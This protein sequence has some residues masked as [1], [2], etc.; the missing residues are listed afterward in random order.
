MIT[1]R[2]TTLLGI[3]HPIVLGGMAGSTNPAMVAAVSNAGGLGIIGSSGRS[4]DDIAAQADGIRRLTD[5]PFGLNL[6]L[7]ENEQ[8]VDTVLAARPTI[9][10]TAW[11]TPE[12]DLAAIFARAHA[13]GIPVMHMVAT[14]PEARRAARA[15]ADLIVAQGTVGG[16][17]IGLMSTL[18]L[19]PQVARA[20]APIPVLAAGGLADGAG[21]AA[22]LMLGAEGI[23]LG[24]RFLA[25]T[26]APVPES[27]KQA[28]I[29]SDGHDAE[30]TESPDLISGRLWPGA[31]GRVLRNRLIDTWS[32]REGALRANRAEIAAG[33]ARARRE[34]D[35]EGGIIWS[36][37]SAGLI[38][39]IEPAATIIERIVRDAE[40]IIRERLESMMSG[41]KRQAAE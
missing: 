35:T 11:P 2:A 18:V 5:R 34:G 28:L 32:G 25:S 7:F 30:V 3:S 24:T 19:V 22:A 40:A 39:R 14:L 26:E 41:A 10:S 38:D 8:H 37:Q 6:L 17:H 20:V 9:L 27:Y 12:Q 1:T 21:L 16:G 13:A 33:T 15:G 31:Y 4:P 23:L 36:G 29:E